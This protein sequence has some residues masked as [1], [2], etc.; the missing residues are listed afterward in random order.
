MRESAENMA[1]LAKKSVPSGR[2]DR[3]ADIAY[4]EQSRE[5]LGCFFCV[6]I[7]KN[8]KRLF[9]DEREVAIIRE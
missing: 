9:D 6:V 5:Y 4:T 3:G 2:K 1:F 8:P 7:L